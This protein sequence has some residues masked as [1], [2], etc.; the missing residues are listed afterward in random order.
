MLTDECFEAIA[1]HAILKA[2][3]EPIMSWTGTGLEASTKQSAC[4][5]G[6]EPE[7]HPAAR[8]ISKLVASLL[9]WRSSST[10]ERHRSPSRS[11]SVAACD[12]A[13]IARCLPQK[14]SSWT[15]SQVNA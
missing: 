6:L 1:E 3:G 13:V 15:A 7:N 12:A 4:Q 9:P 10:V 2:W 14:T 5:K 8:P 11:P